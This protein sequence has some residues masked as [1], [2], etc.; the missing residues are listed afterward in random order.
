MTC[1]DVSMS[2]EDGQ[3]ADAWTAE[4]KGRVH[5]MAEECTFWSDKIQKAPA[6]SPGLLQYVQ[7]NREQSCK[8]SDQNAKA[9]AKQDADELEAGKPWLEMVEAEMKRGTC[10]PGY[11]EA[12]EALL[13]RMKTN[14]S[15]RRDEGNTLHMVAFVDHR[16]VVAKPEGTAFDFSDWGNATVHVFAIAGLPVALD[17][18]RGA[19]AMTLPSPWAKGVHTRTTLT[20]WENNAGT[21]LRIVHP[22]LGEPPQIWARKLPLGMR[23]TIALDSRVIQTRPGERVRIVLQGRGCAL[24]AAFR[25]LN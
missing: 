17:V 15:T 7:I 6:T 2:A 12:L 3:T 24:L 1:H 10:D 19:D 13:L 18:H 20:G 16:I 5:T 11:R 22:K 9:S 21:T 14:L 8:E 4:I 25:D 23:D